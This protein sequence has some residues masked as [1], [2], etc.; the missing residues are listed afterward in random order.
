MSAL[1]RDDGHGRCASVSEKHVRGFAD[2][3]EVFGCD[4]E[5][6]GCVDDLGDE[7]ADFIGLEVHE[8]VDVLGV[9][10]EKC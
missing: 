10:V 5:G 8:S 9:K 3:L 1:A 7:V 4:A 2:G 6:E